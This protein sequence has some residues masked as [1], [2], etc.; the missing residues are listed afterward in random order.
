MLIPWASHIQQPSIGNQEI[1]F[2]VTSMTGSFD[3]KT[4]TTFQENV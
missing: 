3:I 2:I 4:M 1:N